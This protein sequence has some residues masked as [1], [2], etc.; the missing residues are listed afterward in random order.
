MRLVLARPMVV[1]PPGRKMSIPIRGP[2]MR[3]LH[4]PFSDHGLLTPGNPFQRQDM[5]YSFHVCYSSLARNTLQSGR[6][7]WTHNSKVWRYT[8]MPMRADSDAGVLGKLRPDAC[9]QGGSAYGD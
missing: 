8:R 6:P 5:N 2:D 1:S 3:G 9:P 4:L 7:S